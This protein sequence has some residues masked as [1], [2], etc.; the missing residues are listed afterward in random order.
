MEDDRIPEYY[1]DEINLIDYLRVLWKWKWLIIAGTLIC[2]IVAAVISLQMPRIYEISTVI[3][4][5]IAGVKDDGSFIYIDS[6]GNISGKIN[7]GAYNRKI[8]E[9]FHLDPL[10]TGVKFKPVIPK[11]TNVIKVTSYWEEK[12]T[13]L[14]MEVIGHLIHLLSGDYEKV[15]E[16]RKGIYDGQI[17]IKQ[18][19]IKKLEVQRE[20][21]RENL[22]DIKH[23]MDELKKEMNN[24]KNNTEYLTTQ[25]DLLLKK[26]KAEVQMP[27]LLYS[28]TIQQ[29]ICYFNEINDQIY[30]FKEK[31][32][33]AQ[34]E[35]KNLEKDIDTAKIEITALNA[36]KGMISNIKTIQKPEVSLHPVKP[37][38]K[39][40]VLL[41]GVVALFMFVFLAFFIEYI[42]NASKNG[43]DQ[44]G[45]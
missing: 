13:G 31:E 10:K 1:E 4:P 44:K 19:D 18:N 36:K 40:I 38:K 43:A 26:G 30:D 5:G 25:R 6:V 17:L 28:T 16:H 14:G 12:D 27:L 20:S 11:S 45:K 2:A 3:E 8:E 42:K 32:V 9:A 41:T 21:L 7:E 23:R 35:I 24:V 34:Q 15:L 39:Q 33:G 37:K 22:K 29:N